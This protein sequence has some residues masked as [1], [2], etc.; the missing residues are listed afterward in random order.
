L[1]LFGT[2]FTRREDSNS[3]PIW[4]AI[5]EMVWTAVTEPRHLPSSSLQT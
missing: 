5:Q 2:R 1:S 4:E 3:E